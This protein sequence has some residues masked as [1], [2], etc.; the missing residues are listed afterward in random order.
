MAL[1]IKVMNKKL[2]VK[3]HIPFCFSFWGGVGGHSTDVP[4]EKPPLLKFLL[5][6]SSPEPKAHW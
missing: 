2:L 4:H 5:I 1:Q 6:F 3:F